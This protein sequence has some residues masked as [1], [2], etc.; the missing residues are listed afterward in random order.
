MIC[1]FPSMPNA[2]HTSS[3]VKGSFSDTSPRSC[4]IYC[5]VRA[6]D[7]VGKMKCTSGCMSL[8]I[9]LHDGHCEQLSECA[10]LRQ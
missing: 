10:R 7:A 5:P 2:E 9:R 3:S 1:L 6:D 4:A 8:S